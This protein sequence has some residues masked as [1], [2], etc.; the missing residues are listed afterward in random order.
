MQIKVYTVDFELPRWLKRTIIYGAIPGLVFA[1]GA[2][3]HAQAGDGGAPLNVFANGETLSAERMNANFAVLESQIR[4]SNAVL[5]SV[6]QTM[7]VQDANGRVGIGTTLP[8]AKVEIENNT[9]K[10]SDLLLL[11]HNAENT[12]SAGHGAVLGFGNQIAGEEGSSRIAAKIGGFGEQGDGTPGHLSFFVRHG[13][14][15]IPE[16]LRIDTNGNVG[17]G[18]TNPTAKLQAGDSTNRGGIEPRTD[19]SDIGGI[20]AA[21]LSRLGGWFQSNPIPGGAIHFAAQ[22]LNGQRGAIAF[23][24]KAVDDSTSQPLMRM[25]VTQSGD[26]GI[27]TASPGFRLEVN[28]SAAKPG[29]GSWTDSSDL[30]L[31]ENIQTLQGALDRLLGL[32][33]VTF[34][35]REPENHGGFRGT[36]IG[37]IAQEVERIFPEWV[38]T[39]RNGFKTLTFRGFE[40]LAVES[41]RALKAEN[42]GLNTK[43]ASLEERIQKLEKADMP[44]SSSM[45]VLNARLN[46]PTSLWGIALAA[47]GLGALWASRRKA[48][49]AQRGP[50][51][52][53]C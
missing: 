3:V 13:D 25:V 16:R 34:E 6:Q 2:V 8:G 17:I 51:G 18:M 42:T 24:T 39:D 21:Q 46:T 26:V 5:T 27:G 15:D 4:S 48:S 35:W 7:I 29:G 1:A 49:P 12:Y 32:R 47:F 33:G 43:I 38:G 28:G 23:L 52:N 41:M 10:G 37:M 19:G 53:A 36:Q 20:G 14:G 44:Q 22:G 9:V 40:A 50:S 45:G 31:K 30:R 11:L